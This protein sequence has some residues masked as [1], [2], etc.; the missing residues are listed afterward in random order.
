LLLRHA[1]SS[2]DEPGLDDHDRP[3]APRGVRAVERIATYMEERRLHADLVLCSSARRAR[4]TLAGLRPDLDDVD[5][6]IEDELYGASAYAL[7]QRLRRV[8]ASVVSVMIIGHNPGLEDLAVALARDGDPSAMERL[9]TKFPTTALAIFDVDQDDW[10]R[11]GNG[12]GYL[13]EL[14]LPREL[15]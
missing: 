10:T 1:K 9:H 3:L 12:D 6:D 15:S 2:W 11:L 7:V 14:V 5:V 13:R 8:D 4:Q